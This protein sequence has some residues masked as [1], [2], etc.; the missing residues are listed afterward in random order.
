M[1]ID[2]RPNNLSATD[3]L[4]RL[5]DGNE[6]FVAGQTTSPTSGP[7]RHLDHSP[8]AVVLAS[9]DGHSAPE[10]VFDEGLGALFVIRVAGNIVDDSILGS[11]E[12][13]VIHM[14]VNLVV[15]M[16]SL[17]CGLV[18][19]AVDHFDV[20]SPACHNHIDSLIDAIRPA[21][22]VALQRGTDDL[23]RRSIEENARLMATK[24]RESQPI[25]KGLEAKGVVVRPA[26]YSPQTGE[27]VWL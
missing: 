3:A 12:H 4:D 7:Q 10:L 14:G 8:F 19:S 5:Q 6:R 27:V 20:P 22:Q 1:P 13:A 25:V 11:V 17:S 18:Q 15:V 16:G 21:V 26:C 23:L 24:I 2:I 9:S